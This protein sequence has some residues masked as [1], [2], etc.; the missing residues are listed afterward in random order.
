[1]TS[2]LARPPFEHASLRIEK[3]STVFYFLLCPVWVMSLVVF[4]VHARFLEKQG[5]VQSLMCPGDLCG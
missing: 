4:A 3:S 1:M 5:R 2:L